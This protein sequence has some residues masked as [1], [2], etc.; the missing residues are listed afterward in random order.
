MRVFGE[1]SGKMID[2]SLRR[3]AVAVIIIYQEYQKERRPHHQSTQTL[4]TLRAGVWAAVRLASAACRPPCKTRKAVGTTVHVTEQPPKRNL[5][6]SP[7]RSHSHSVGPLAS[8]HLHG[9]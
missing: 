1:S 4:E 6:F 9:P 7:L 8:S 2:T 3:N 5:P